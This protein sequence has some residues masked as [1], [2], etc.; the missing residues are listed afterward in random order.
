MVLE[1]R[2]PAKSDRALLAEN[3]RDSRI[4]TTL[5]S[6]GTKGDTKQ[7]TIQQFLSLSAVQMDAIEE[8]LQDGKNATPV[9]PTESVKRKLRQQKGTHTLGNRRESTIMN[10]DSHFV[11]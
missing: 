2:L 1:S 11:C 9:E 4:A 10:N 8:P 3:R 5:L 6:P 7:H